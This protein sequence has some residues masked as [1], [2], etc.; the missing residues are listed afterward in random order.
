LPALSL[1]TEMVAVEPSR[2]ALTTTPSI[3]PSAAELTCPV[4]AIASASASAQKRAEADRDR[5]GGQ[6]EQ[7]TS[8][9]HERL[10]DRRTFAFAR[11]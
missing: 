4:N 1:T 3:G 9:M 8:R 2:L 7:K 6:G 10:L 5:A 11:T